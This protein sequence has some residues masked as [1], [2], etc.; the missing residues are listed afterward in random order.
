M[1]AAG[2]WEEGVAD[3]E[4]QGMVLRGHHFLEWHPA[5]L[6][7]FTRVEVNRLRTLARM[8]E[9]HHIYVALIPSEAVPV[10]KS[11]NGSEF[12]VDAC[13]LPYFTRTS[14]SK[15]F[16][17]IQEPAWQLPLFGG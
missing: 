14:L 6:R 8:H 7:Y 10:P 11:Q 13:L 3:T 12:T 15:A 16:P 9:A 4:Y 17:L 1:Q 5:T 2:L